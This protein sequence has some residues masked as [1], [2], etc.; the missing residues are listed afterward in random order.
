L[1]WAGFPLAKGERLDSWK[2]L[3]TWRDTALVMFTL[4]TFGYPMSILFRLTQS[5]WEIGNR[6]GPYAFLGVGVI[7]A[8]GVVCL[9]QSNSKSVFRAAT[10]G[11]ACAI[12]VVGGVMSSEGQLMLVPKNY[13]V[14][15]D[16]A[17]VEPMG[18]SAAKWTEQ[19]LGPG[20]R[21]TADRVNSLLLATYGRQRPG[22]TLQLGIDAGVALFADKFG[23]KERAIL[24]DVDTDYIFADLRL[25]TAPPLL[26]VSFDGASSDQLSDGRPPRAESLLKFDKV[27]SFSRVFDNGYSIIYD[28]RALHAP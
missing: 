18:I 8:I 12:I 7:L 26:G 5:G 16:A 19:W 4:L 11:I 2:Q 15:A 6:I 25:T 13:E 21:F 23:D 28:V 14:S 17:S 22:T 24:A 27:R 9:F 3:F 10:I 20:N 1:A